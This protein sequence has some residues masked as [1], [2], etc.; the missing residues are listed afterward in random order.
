MSERYIVGLDI[1]QMTD[2]TAIC[3]LHEQPGTQP[4]YHCI[5]LERVP[6]G[7]SYPVV[8]SRVAEIMQTP[9]LRYA[10]VIV[11][12]T[13]V[14]RALLDMLSRA[15]VRA[16]AV[17]ITGGDSVTREGDAFRVPKRDLVSVVQ[18]LL[19][20]HRLLIAEVLAEAE[21]LVKELLNFQVRITLAGHDQYGAWREGT[22]DD[23]VLAV[24]LACWYGETHPVHRFE[25][26]SSGPSRWPS[27][28]PLF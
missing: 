17:T 28:P 22:H 10:P 4:A 8:V 9:L 16:T 15:G 18:V 13:G 23:L 14:G 21:A 6:F 5:H 20:S 1:G 19:Q 26:T 3:V 2:F 12:A 27:G 25:F 11:D 7:T 24:A